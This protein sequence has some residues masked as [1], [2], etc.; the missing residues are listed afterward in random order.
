MTTP[1]TTPVD[2]LL[3]LKALGFGTWGV[4]GWL[5]RARVEKPVKTFAERYDTAP[6][7]ICR[8][9]ALHIARLPKTRPYDGR[10]AASVRLAYPANEV[11]RA[12]FSAYC[13]TVETNKPLVQVR[14]GPFA[15]VYLPG[16]LQYAHGKENKT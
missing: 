4:Y 3:V 14:Q 8:T 5:E 16:R 15:H 6:A 7:D 2:L 13:K 11:E 12:I 1:V 9:L 10:D